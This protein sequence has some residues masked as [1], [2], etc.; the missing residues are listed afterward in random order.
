MLPLRIVFKLKDRLKQ[1][2]YNKS[3]AEK[4]P[5]LK[6]HNSFSSVIPAQAGIQSM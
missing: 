6:D 2:E 3:H 1:R 4:V 5:R